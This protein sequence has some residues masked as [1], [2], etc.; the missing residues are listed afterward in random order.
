MRFCRYYLKKNIAEV[1]GML[2][3]DCGAGFDGIGLSH[4]EWS[5]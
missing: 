5:R 1:S 4:Q 2:P 3:K